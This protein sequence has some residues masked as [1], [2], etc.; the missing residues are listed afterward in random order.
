MKN[1][2]LQK[3]QRKNINLGNTELEVTAV[4]TRLSCVY[5]VSLGL[6]R[7]SISKTPNLS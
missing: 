5:L 6:P 1:I 3:K 7:V 2:V 4:G